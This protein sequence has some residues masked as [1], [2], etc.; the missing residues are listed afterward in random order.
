MK[1][2]LLKTK[3]R[4]N[5]L[6]KTSTGFSN[7][8]LDGSINL[9]SDSLSNVERKGLLTNLFLMARPIITSVKTRLRLKSGGKKPIFPLIKALC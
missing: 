9:K 8:V 2:N 1:V 3:V 7:T 6:D 4:S 5:P